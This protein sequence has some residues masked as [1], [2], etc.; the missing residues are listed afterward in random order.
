[1]KFYFDGVLQQTVPGPPSGAITIDRPKVLTST[2]SGQWI[3]G[4]IF[5]SRELLSED[6]VIALAAG[7]MPNGRGVLL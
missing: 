3:F 4:N 1:M 5:F 2:G 6:A 7:R